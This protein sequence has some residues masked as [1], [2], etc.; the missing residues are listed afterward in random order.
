MGENMISHTICII[1]YQQSLMNVISFMFIWG[2]LKYIIRC[3]MSVLFPV[4]TVRGK[5]GLW[6]DYFIILVEILHEKLCI[7]VK[8]SH[9]TYKFVPGDVS[10]V[11]YLEPLE[12]SI[13]ASTSYEGGLVKYFYKQE[14]YSSDH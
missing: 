9:Y 6:I 2:Y 11:I 5:G 10:K 3:T 8:L 14:N 1:L 7:T 13:E 4:N 12:L